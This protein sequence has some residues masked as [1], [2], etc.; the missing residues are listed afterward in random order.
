M[1]DKS[2]SAIERN[3]KIQDI[4][5]GK[6]E[7][8]KV[9]AAKKAAAAT[10]EPESP[11]AKE[12]EC[13]EGGNENVNASAP[14]GGEA[15][16][17]DMPDE[18]NLA[19]AKRKAVQAVMQDKSLSA[20]ERNKKI[21]DIMAGKVELPKVAAAKKAAA[22]TTESEP[23]PLK[24]SKTKA[25]KEEKMNSKAA[26]EPVAKKPTKTKKSNDPLEMS[27]ISLNPGHQFQ[28][29]DSTMSYDFGT[30]TA[31]AQDWKQWMMTTHPKAIDNPLDVLLA[32]KYRLSLR[33]APNQ[34]SF[35]VVAVV[36]FSRSQREER[37]HV[38]GTNDE[39]HSVSGSIC[40][41]RAALMQLRFVLDLEEI[42]KIIITTDDVDP[43]SPGML[44]REFM[45]SFKHMSD[46]TPIILGRSVC[47]KCGLNLSG[48]ACG[49]NG[50][51]VP[52]NLKAVH[53]KIFEECG[54]KKGSKYPSPH[55]FVG[56][57][58]SLR[59]LFPY[60]SLYAGLSSVDAFKFGQTYAAS[61]PNHNPN[62]GTAPVLT[63]S[64]KSTRTTDSTVGSYR[65]ERF[66]LSM[67]SAMSEDDPSTPGARTPNRK[68]PDPPSG[69]FT[70]SLKTTVDFMRQIREDGDDNQDENGLNEMTPGVMHHLTAKSLKISAR[71]K[72]SQRRDK[73]IRL[74]TEATATEIPHRRIHPIRDGAA[75]LFSDNTVAL[76][77]Q[78][79]ALE[80]G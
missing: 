63:N 21:Q 31:I 70:A 77:S 16:L 8:P 55:D 69:S 43:I 66:D 80:Y 75:V 13:M 79:I 39:P 34:S 32:H 5:A 52:E 42:T 62:E 45:S 48:K 28:R 53:E 15:M 59:E 26:A 20:I 25:K 17:T 54:T 46:S 36:F 60:P 74:A 37:F 14:T 11:A 64:I 3:K 57:N 56:S 30:P 23:A 33:S 19:L 73:L 2:L 78:N 4:M 67:I 65:Q 1:Q 40:A 7:L 6:V 61:K 68:T 58:T 47:R 18:D 27:D 12:K 10:M 35:R 76:A 41:E 38:V 71:L 49:D 51:F 24:S 9:A 29:K 50:E 44:C 22:A 72:Q